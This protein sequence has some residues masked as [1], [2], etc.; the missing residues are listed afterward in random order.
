MSFGTLFR[1]CRPVGGGVGDAVRSAYFEG[2]I[3]GLERGKAKDETPAGAGE[4]SQ[5]SL[6]LEEANVS[7]EEVEFDE[8]KVGGLVW[9][10]SERGRHLLFVCTGNTCRSPMAEGLFR[11]AASERGYTVSSAGV[12]AMPG[13]RASR[14]TVEIVE[15]AGGELSGFSSRMVDEDILREA[16]HVFCMTRSHLDTLEM[17]YPEFR[18]RYY[19]ACDFVDID[20]E[21]GVDVP[22]PIGGGRGAYRSVRDVL[23]GAIGG[24]LGFLKVEKR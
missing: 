4:S 18:E 22:D 11:V 9:R 17:L 2:E 14:E 15:A 24:I 3:M 5:L 13:S 19:L 16:S 10:M 23:D 20:G 1:A 8:R 7:W 12:A 6:R 21:V